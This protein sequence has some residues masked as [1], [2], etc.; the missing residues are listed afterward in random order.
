MTYESRNMFD[1]LKADDEETGLSTQ[2]KVRKGVVGAM[3]VPP[4]EAP[5]ETPKACFGGNQED[6]SCKTTPKGRKSASKILQNSN[7]VN[8]NGTNAAVRDQK[9]RERPTKRIEE[10]K[11]RP[12][13]EEKKEVPKGLQVL[14]RMPNPSLGVC[15]EEQQQKWTRI[16]MAVDS[17]ACD[18]VADPEQMPCTVNETPA[19]RSGANFA[20]ATGEPIPNLGE[21]KLPLMMREGT[22]RSM[23]VTAAPVTKPLASVKKI[24]Q[25]GHRVVFDDDGSYIVNKTTGEVNLLREEEGNYML[26]MWIMPST[27]ESTFHGR[28]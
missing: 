27:P 28:R 5:A 17:G 26:D 21:M 4:D 20:S 10:Q 1:V 9:G 12:K 7:C 22:C 8:V 18:S 24:C 19:S 13:G 2:G 3:G 6:P 15:T 11:E 16:S 25:A 23:K 14:T